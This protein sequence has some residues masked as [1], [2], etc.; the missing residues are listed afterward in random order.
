MAKLYEAYVGLVSAESDGSRSISPQNA[1]NLLLNY[2]WVKTG[3]SIQQV[4]GVWEGKLEP[5][6]VIRKVQ[7]EELKGAEWEEFLSALAVEFRQ[8]CVLGTVSEVGT[9]WESGPAERNFP[10]PKQVSVLT[11]QD[12]P[13][14]QA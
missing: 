11:G 13:P 12:V 10:F 1:V 3:C 8:E 6:L 2:E 7:E 14:A 5:C 9:H 4:I